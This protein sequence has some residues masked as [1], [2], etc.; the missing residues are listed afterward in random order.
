[1]V[2]AL[3]RMCWQLQPCPVQQDPLPHPSAVDPPQPSGRD[4]GELV[5]WEAPSSTQAI[6]GWLGVSPPFCRSKNGKWKR[7][8]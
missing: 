2:L 3:C 4:A 8:K 5:F 6:L 7:D 1:M